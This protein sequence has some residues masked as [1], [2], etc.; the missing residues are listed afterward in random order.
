MF[1]RASVVCEG[2]MFGS[3]IEIKLFVSF[4]CGIGQFLQSE[5]KLYLRNINFVVVAVALYITFNI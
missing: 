1:V 2:L 4:D 3:G 5:L